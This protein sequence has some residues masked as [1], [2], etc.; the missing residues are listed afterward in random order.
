M[1]KMILRTAVCIAFGGDKVRIREAS[2][3]RVLVVKGRGESLCNVNR[4]KSPEL[5]SF[6]EKEAAGF[7]HVGHGRTESKSISKSPACGTRR[8]E[9]VLMGR[10]PHFGEKVGCSVNPC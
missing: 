6:M 10:G 2:E 8:M 1:L 9:V 7:G 5:V 3:E 4:K